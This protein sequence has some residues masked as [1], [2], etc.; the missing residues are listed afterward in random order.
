MLLSQ[1]AHTQ[2]MTGEFVVE[3]VFAGRSEGKGEVRLVWVDRRP[4]AVESLGTMQG[5]RF[6]LEQTL[7]FEGKPAQS[8]SWVLW[9]TT[10]GHYS[11]TLTDAA[12]PVIG[13]TEGSR[14]TLQYPLNRWGLVMY[15][16]LDLADE[17]TVLNSG[18][19]RFL[20]IPVGEVRE[21]ILLKH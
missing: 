20:G 16:T 14:L 3:K 6:R 8:R 7:R 17:H 18:S 2:S 15:Q 13:R 12:G 10:P 21:T 1:I 4:F 11:A 9:Q 19:I 5:G